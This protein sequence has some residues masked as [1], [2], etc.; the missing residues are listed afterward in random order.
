[1]LGIVTVVVTVYVVIST[2][3]A[4]DMRTEPKL[5]EPPD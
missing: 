5:G 4:Y 3:N 1:L 2:N